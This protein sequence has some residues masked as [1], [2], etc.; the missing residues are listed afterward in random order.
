MKLKDMTAAE[1]MALGTLVRRLLGMDGEFSAEEAAKLEK[2][3]ERLGKEEFWQT[4]EDAGQQDLSDNALKARA[5]AV[6]RQDVQETIYRNLFAIA[7]A[8]TIVA[9]EDSL[10]DW[11]SEAWGLEKG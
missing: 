9:Q 3:A 6:D 11:L 1:R 10:L 4:I 8:G 2:A 7:T 5:K